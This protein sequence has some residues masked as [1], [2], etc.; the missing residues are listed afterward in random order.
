[1][2]GAFLYSALKPVPAAIRIFSDGSNGQCTIPAW[3]AVQANDHEDFSTCSL[4]FAVSTTLARA[5]CG[6]S[7]KVY[8][9]RP[10]RDRCWDNGKS[11]GKAR[12]GQF[13]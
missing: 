11:D 5:D 12:F 10:R 8:E 9:R 2:P 3:C 4:I 13:K 7:D 6:L 1:M